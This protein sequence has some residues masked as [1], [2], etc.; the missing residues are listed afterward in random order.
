[1]GKINVIERQIHFSYTPEFI[2]KYKQAPPE[3]INEMTKIGKPQGYSAM[4][5]F[6]LTM[7]QFTMEELGGLPY[8]PY[9]TNSNG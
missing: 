2:E 5:T 4:N 9:K 7:F 6:Y 1:M 8:E 3:M